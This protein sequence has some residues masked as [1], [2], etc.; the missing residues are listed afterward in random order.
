MNDVTIINGVLSGIM[1]IVF[2][3]LLTQFGA[4]LI[5]RTKE[6][7]TMLGGILCVFCGLMGLG[8]IY[9]GVSL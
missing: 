7:L 9:F 5:T 3:I 2:L 1:N 8:M 4:G 6:G